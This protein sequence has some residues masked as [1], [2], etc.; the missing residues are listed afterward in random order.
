MELYLIFFNL[1]FS[2]SSFVLN[3]R[4]ESIKCPAIL[5]CQLQ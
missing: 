5:F 4:R 2:D 3:E 1:R